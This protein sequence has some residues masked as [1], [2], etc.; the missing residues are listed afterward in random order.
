MSQAPRLS[1]GILGRKREGARRVT[2]TGYKFSKSSG[3]AWD[4]RGGVS[5]YATGK[6]TRWILPS[7]EFFTKGEHVMVSLGFHLMSG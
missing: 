3:K 7:A 2:K 5:V 1:A 6:T 4:W